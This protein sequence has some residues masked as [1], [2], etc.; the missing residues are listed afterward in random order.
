LLGSDP[1]ICR[2]L[3]HHK[4]DLE[5]AFRLTG[6]CKPQESRQY[7]ETGGIKPM[8]TETQ[9][10]NEVNGTFYDSETPMEVVRILEESRRNKLRLRLHYG[11]TETGRDWM[12][13][14]GVTGHISRS[15]GPIKIPIMVSSSRAMG[16]GGILDHC[17]VRIRTAAGNRE[18]YRHPKYNQP[19]VSLLVE[20]MKLPYPFKVF[21]D[22]E[23]TA[24]FENAEKRSNW[25]KKL[26]VGEPCAASTK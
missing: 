17:I 1:D 3:A 24:G 26:D 11:D 18:L 20:D 2:L 13:A 6:S 22:G 7:G 21:L 10:Y 8:E 14:W 4:A 23:L 12:D 25:L 15:M 5:G 16:G 19:K 9:K